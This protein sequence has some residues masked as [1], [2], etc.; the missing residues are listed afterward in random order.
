MHR[1]ASADALRKNTTLTFLN[2]HYNQFRK[3][4]LQMHLQ[5]HHAGFSFDLSHNGLELG[6]EK[7]FIDAFARASR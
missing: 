6:G 5:E 3:K 7:A 2:P 1:K 4:H